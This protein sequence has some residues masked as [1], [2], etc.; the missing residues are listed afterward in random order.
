M[1]IAL[2]LCFALS[3]LGCKKAPPPAV[4]ALPVAAPDPAPSDE[5]PTPERL[6]PKG[7]N[8]DFSQPAANTLNG[9]PD[10]PKQTDFDNVQADGQRK[11]QACLDAI[12]ANVALPN[13]SARVVIKLTVANDGKPKDVTVTSEIPADAMAC[14]KSSI[15]GL[16]F[17]PFKGSTVT[18][19]FSLAYHRAAAP[20]P[21]PVK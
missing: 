18:T 11:V 19:S 16:V 5:P 12:P 9:D 8:F 1:R 21:A 10:G 6:P 14:A 17:P 7:R 4:V 20:A 3:L 2:P 13:D 15:E